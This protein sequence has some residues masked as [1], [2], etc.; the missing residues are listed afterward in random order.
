MRANQDFSYRITETMEVHPVFDFIQKTSG[1]NDEEMYGNF[2]MGAGFVVFVRPGDAQSAVHLIED[3]TNLKAKVIGSV[4][5]GPK[6][7]VI[8]PLDIGFGED[9]L[10][11]RS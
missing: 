2:N 9:T 7:V 10:E 11:V 5:N 3:Y 6:Q 8:E 4:E 1:N